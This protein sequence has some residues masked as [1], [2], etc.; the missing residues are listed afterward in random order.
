MKY[1]RKNSRIPPLIALGVLLMMVTGCRSTGSF[2]PYHFDNGDDYYREGMQRIVDENGLVGFRDSMGDIS[3]TPRFAFAFP[4]KNGYARV[5]YSGKMESAAPG[6]EHTRWTSDSWRY[7]DRYGNEYADTVEVRGR[8]YDISDGT[9]LWNALIKSSGGHHTSLS[10]KDGTFH[11]RASVGDSI[12]IGYVGLIIRTIPV[13]P[14]DS[15]EWNVGMEQVP[16]IIEPALIHSF[17][18]QE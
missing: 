18:P 16:P 5:T 12:C 14:A 8:V 1:Y 15:T 4:F 9:P 6:S 10:A 17:L 7:I 11:I 13:S 3:I 2:H